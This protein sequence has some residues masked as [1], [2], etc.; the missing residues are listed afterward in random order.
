MVP[1]SAL[2]VQEVNWASREECA[3]HAVFPAKVDSEFVFSG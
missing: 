1:L 2:Y 3:R